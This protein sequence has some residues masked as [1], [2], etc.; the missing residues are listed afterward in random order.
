MSS[1]FNQLGFEK[2]APAPQLTPPP[3]E[4]EKVTEA[5][6][7]AQQ[8]VDLARGSLDFLA[9][10][11][12]PAVYQYAY[13]PVFLAVWDWLLSYV[14]RVRDFSQLALGLP[15]GFSKTTVMKLFILY[16][17][18]FTAKKF[19]LIVAENL[20][21]A[22]NIV[23]DIIDM[24]NEENIKKIFGDWK[25]GIETDRQDLK[26][27]GFRG[28]DIILAALGSGGDPRGLNIKN[29]RP[30]IILM[31]DIQS[32]ECAD[33]EQQSD[34]LERWIYGTLMKAK[35][36]FGCMF[37]FTANMYPTK[38]SILRKIKSNP[39]WIKFITGGILE[40]GVSLWEDLQ[41]IYQLLREY[42]NDL[43]SGHPEIFYAEVLNDETASANNLIDL[44][45][46][47]ELP[48]E[49]GD[50]PAGNFIVID[51]STGKINS[52][53]VAIGYF[54]VYEGYPVLRELV[55]ARL[56]PGDTISQAL[57]LALKHNC[58][59][60]GCEAVAYQSTLLY[61]FRF[62]CEQRGLY[63]IEFVELYPGGMSKNSRILN[64]FK[65][66]SAGEVFVDPSVR[67]EVFLQIMQFNPLRRD[68]TDDIL[69]L[70]TYAPRAIELYGEYIVSMIV[71]INDENR[72]IEVL[73]AGVNSAF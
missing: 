22:E 20:R 33:S 16:C 48:F 2:P 25:L 30:D 66:L 58:R 56:S 7:Q 44:S 1:L 21:K 26:K 68:N 39:N 6:F 55:N 38:W 47:P 59:L 71:I 67:G 42:E 57:Q 53:S 28:R 60:I 54:E 72:N 31:D 73:P 15:R 50:I 8:V 18:L 29:Q 36:P 4:E 65:M 43:A 13:P 12:M 5:A 9:G 35:S 49:E 52:D 34:A 37:L 41:P 3:P 70:L 51:P 14:S 24:L 32:R 23:A 45:K 46:L 19:I 61:W 69:D 64:M 27:F 11:A 10:L 40:G 17:I 63:G 62:V